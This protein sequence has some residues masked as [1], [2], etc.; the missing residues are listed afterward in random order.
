MK[1]RAV[2]LFTMAMVRVKTKLKSMSRRRSAD[3]L[4]AA[5]EEIFLQ[6]QNAESLIKTDV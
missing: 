2:A 3:I 6:L 5:V 1:L 4:R